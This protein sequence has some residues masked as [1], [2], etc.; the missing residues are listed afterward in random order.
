MSVEI[1]KEVVE[2][3]ALIKADLKI[4]ASTGVGVTSAALYEQL[5]PEGLTMDQ[6]KALQDHNSTVFAAAALAVGESSIP[7]MKDNKDLEKVTAEILVGHKDKIKINFDRE[8]SFPDQQTKGTITKMGQVNIGYDMY[9]T[10][11]RGEV[12]KVKNFLTEM[13]LEALGGK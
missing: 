4:D 5:L 3:A 1:K 13:A 12:T 7:L 2:M 11:N 6:V 9:G 10:K 8:R